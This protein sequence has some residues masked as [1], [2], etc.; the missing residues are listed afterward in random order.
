MKNESKFK[1]P[2]EDTFVEDETL[3]ETLL[4][5]EGT[6]DDNEGTLPSDGDPHH[7]TIDA[8]YDDSPLGADFQLQGSKYRIVKVLGQGGFGV[9]YEGVQTGLNRKVAIKEFYMKERC[10]RTST[11][12]M[13]VK[14]RSDI[15]IIESCKEKFL[16]EARLIASLEHPN[17][18]KIIDVFPENNTAYYTM[19]YI[20]GGAL[21]GYVEKH[22]PLSE[23][24]ALRLIR[25]LAAALDYVHKR[26]ILHLDVKP[27]NVMLKDKDTAV[28]IDFG[29]SKHYNE[30]GVQT[31]TSAVGISRGYAPIEQYNEGGVATFSPSTDIYSLGATLFFMLTGKRPPEA[32][33][34]FAVGLPEFPKGISKTV[35]EA[36]TQSMRP[37]RP[38]RPQNIDEFLKLLGGEQIVPTEAP[39]M[40]HIIE[41]LE[42]QG[43]YKEAYLKCMECIDKHVEVE[44]AQK[45][46]ET[47]IPLMKKQGKRTSNIMYVLAVIATILLFAMGFVFTYYNQ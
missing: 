7:D 23:K 44:F 33:T 9:S 28:L 3:D 41:Q 45:K 34:V 42:I 13:I 22:G 40:R 4:E 8:V 27:A 20:E 2:E 24:H 14:N 30:K 11:S 47:L 31:T 35:R 6:L 37:S 12:Q 10:S 43:E 29:I 32:Q 21:Q 25:Q 26:K 46:C 18:V 39:Q 36:I 5:E 38:D 19:E 16:K 1:K 17:I 15:R